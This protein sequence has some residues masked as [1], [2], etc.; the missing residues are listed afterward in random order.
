MVTVSVLATLSC[1]KEIASAALILA[2][3]TTTKANV[4]SCAK[5]MKYSTMSL[6]NVNVGMVLVS[7][8]M[9]DA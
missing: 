1:S 9:E 5:K 2:C 3:S 6:K 7:E 4:W 8:K